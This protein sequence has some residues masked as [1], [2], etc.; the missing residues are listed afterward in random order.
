MTRSLASRTWARGTLILC[1]S[2]MAGVACAVPA[3]PPR[4]AQNQ[5]P[6][7]PGTPALAQAR[8]SASAQ[9]V[10]SPQPSPQASAAQNGQEITT[11]EPGKPIEREIAGSQKHSY[12]IALAKGEYAN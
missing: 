5:N 3:L 11:L 6:R 7:V 2:A 9:N 10:P 8:D 1:L 4:H 12:Q